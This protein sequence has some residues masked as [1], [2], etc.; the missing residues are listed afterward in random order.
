M[1]HIDRMLDERSEL[2]IKMGK[3]KAFAKGDIFKTM[4][5]DDQD[6]MIEQHFVMRMYVQ[7]LT[8]RINRAT[9]GHN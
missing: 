3:L 1:N 2:V 4:P 6:L 8:Q 9:A 7:V 5:V